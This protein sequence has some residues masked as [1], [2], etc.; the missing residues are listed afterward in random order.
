MSKKTELA[1]TSDAMTKPDFIPEDQ[2]GTKELAQHIIPPRLKIIQKQSDD[3]L[4]EKYKAG[5]I[6]AVPLMIQLAGRGEPVGFTPV[7]FFVEYCTW[8][9]IQTRGTLPAV[10]A[11]SRDPESELA[12]KARSAELRNVEKC[13]EAEEYKLN[14][15]EHLNYICMF[16]GLPETPI[17]VS[18][19]KT[20]HRAGSTLAG[21][22][23]MRNASI[24]AGHYTMKTTHQSNAQGEWYGFE[25][26]ND[27]WVQDKET[28]DKWADL[29]ELF[30]K[31][32][33]DIDHE[34]EET[35][36]AGEGEF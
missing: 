15:V 14:H 10:R 3:K 32:D 21:L 28:Y 23:R 36:S 17:A 25:L 2:T 19:S 1:N 11:R 9:P 24:F 13:P 29:F 30:S 34:A 22:V 20:Q 4:L 35:V 7:Y 33:I 12:K 5:D 31:A 8:N 27:G 6:I 26:E 18:F 16:D